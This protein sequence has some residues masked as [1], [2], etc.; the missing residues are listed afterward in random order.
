MTTS[1]FKLQFL[2]L[3]ILNLNPLSHILGQHLDDSLLISFQS[4]KRFTA[5]DLPAPQQHVFT[6]AKICLKMKSL[7]RHIMEL[8]QSGFLLIISMHL[9]I[10]LMQDDIVGTLMFENIGINLFE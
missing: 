3:K 5:I 10:V 4:N 7:L 2:D 6:P 9:Q 8:H 1:F